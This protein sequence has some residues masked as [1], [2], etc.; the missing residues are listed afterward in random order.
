MQEFSKI[1]RFL[2]LALILSA[3]GCAW[4]E[5]YV[6]D[7]QEF[8][9]DAPNF[10]KELTDRS[11]VSVCYSRRGA[12]PREVLDLAQTECGKFQKVARFTG[13]ERLACPLVAPVKANFECVKP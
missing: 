9:R 11:S 1:F 8:N 7:S 10:G 13:Q 12:T 6:F 4:A 2:G 5:P 3:G